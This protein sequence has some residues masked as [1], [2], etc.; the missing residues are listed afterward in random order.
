MSDSDYEKILDSGSLEDID[1]F[2]TALEKTGDEEQ[3]AE[4]IAES[5][6]TGE[7]PAAEPRQSAPAGQPI[8]E[9]PD[10]PGV[11][12]VVLT[13]D[14]K[15]TIPYSELE[16]ARRQ[17]AAARQQLDQ[18][19]REKQLLEQQLADANI[20]PK[21]LPE[22]VRFSPEQLAELESYG[23]IGQAVAVLAQ[24]NAVL[25]EQLNDRGITPAQAEEPHNPFAANPDTNR[26]AQDDTSWGIVV[27]VNAALAAD[28]NWASK[29]PEQ[30][31]PEIVR[32]TKLAL[33][34]ATD[35]SL[36]RAA[37]A[38]LQ[39]AART[40]PNSLTDVGGEVSGASKTTAERLADADMQDV[41]AFLQSQ[42]DRGVPMDQAIAGL[43]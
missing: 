18:L 36:D 1:A 41:E 21:Q 3:A 19:A 43:L 2:L 27:N 31:I 10:D 24:Q 6:D 9:Q 13:K 11:E 20:Q 30:R 12:P 28:P 29:S 40:A 33:G 26:W 17:A 39:R 15:H 8:V 22:Q 37:D 16:S 5:G 32:R 23:E 42:L 34:E 25:M 4:L 14:G 38:A 7:L 35:L